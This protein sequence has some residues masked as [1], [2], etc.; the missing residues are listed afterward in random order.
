MGIIRVQT[1]NDDIVR[2]QIQGDEPTEQEMQKI[3]DQFG[4]SNT[5]TTSQ[6]AES[7]QDLVDKYSGAGS[8][9][10]L[11]QQDF[12]TE[13]GIQDAGLRALLSGAENN[14]EEENILATQGFSR[15]D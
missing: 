14:A 8:Q 15:K 3:R 5:Q 1:P 7:F 4:Q 11:V 2:V 13:S 6:G 10:S 12:D 9:R